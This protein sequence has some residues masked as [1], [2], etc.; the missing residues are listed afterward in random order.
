MNLPAAHSLA[1]SESALSRVKRFWE[2]HVNNEYYTRADR[3]SEAYFREIE[4][5]RYRWHYHLVE[6]FRK[7]QGSSGRLL[8]VGCGIGIDSIQLD[9]CGFDVV[10]IDLTESAIEVARR[11][12]RARSVDI[13]FRVGD[14]ERLEFTDGSFDAVHS[15]GVLH[16]TP[17]I[18]QAI[19]E[20]HRVLKPGGTA[21]LMLYH[22]RSL[23]GWI[24]RLL[25]LPYESPRHLKDH[26]PVADS[27]TV[28]EVHRL[29]REFSQV[30]VSLEYPFT[31]GFRYFTFWIPRP[32]QRLLGRW[33]G[34][35]L[36][37]QA[38]R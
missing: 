12:A 14:A 24:H 9:R 8:D 5:R 15:F 1:T 20:I 11:F 32:L 18:E 25:S 34:W 6:L 29:L 35:H 7:L 36:M 31:Y 22:R 27:F 17:R 16:H 4:T 26:C 3:G 30:Q 2:E 21:Y 13:D 33:V 19:A 38:T 28:Q 37:I 23:V 10:A